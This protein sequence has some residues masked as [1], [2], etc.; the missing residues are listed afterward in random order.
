MNT[1]E[2]YSIKLTVIDDTFSKDDCGCE[3]IFS[4]NFL[5]AAIL[6]L[7]IIYDLVIG[8][9]IQLTK[10]EIEVLKHIASGRNNSAIAKRLRISTNTTKI[11]IKN[12][13]Q[14]LAVSDRTQAVVK[15]VKYRLINIY[16]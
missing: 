13:F 8:R 9:K 4:R 11:H 12:I 3:I 1:S 14:K 15:A 16:N 6:N 10:R 5:N 7:F 2:E